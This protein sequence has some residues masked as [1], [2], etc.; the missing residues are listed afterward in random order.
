MCFSSYAKNCRSGHTSQENQEDSY[1]PQRY[2]D[3]NRPIIYEGLPVNQD[4]RTECK[5]KHLGNTPVIYSVLSYTHY[6]N[7][8]D[9]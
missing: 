5:R 2:S 4:V 7:Y 3:I 8:S 9:I 6:P 1:N